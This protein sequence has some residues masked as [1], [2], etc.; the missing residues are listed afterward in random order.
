M[1]SVY[2]SFLTRGVSHH[3]GAFFTLPLFFFFLVRYKETNKISYLIP[4]VFTGGFLVHFEL[5][6][7]IPYLILAYAYLVYLMIKTGHKK[8]LLVLLLIII[9]L[10]NY[11][12]FEL[13]HQ[14]PM[15]SNIKRFLTSHATDENFTYRSIIQNRLTLLLTGIEF[16]RE[17]PHNIRLFFNLAFFFFI[18]LQIKNKVHRN[19]YLIFLYLYFGYFALSFINIGPILHF[20]L[21]PQ[22]SLAFLIF[23][24]LITSRY[25]K[26]LLAVFTAVFILN[27]SAAIRNVR[28][29]ENFI[30]KNPESWRFLLNFS[31]KIYE[32]P[33]DTFGYFV[34][35][36][37]AFGYQPKYAM[38]Y[39]ATLYPKNSFSLEKR[40]VTYTLAAPHP[41][42]KDE[43]WIQNQVKITTDPEWSIKAK[44]GYIIR[45]YRLD[46]DAI[47][48]PFDPAIDP[49]LHFR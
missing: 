8:H 43:W 20:H 34:F 9:P 26:V 47:K 13:R 49:G 10:S 41:Y 22:F 44:N 36:P 38:F 48:I 17:N 19:K 39:T 3:L 42:M 14:S 27:L 12:V 16:P 2:L 37:D 6:I 28:D 24:S 1:A 7:G 33:E 23:A 5:A 45:K 15:I 31:K 4:F 18:L 40:P 11:L 32:Q 46:E 30:G 35:S 21:F 25:K 29:S